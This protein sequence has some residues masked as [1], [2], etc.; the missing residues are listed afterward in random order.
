MESKTGKCCLCGGHFINYGCNP[1]P[2]GDVEIE[3]CCHLCD[4]LYVIPIRMGIVTFDEMTA[5]EQV[6]RRFVRFAKKQ[7]EILE[8]RERERR[9]RSR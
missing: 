7:S 3:K 6:V 4:E 1:D 9:G 5:P 8:Q 2:L